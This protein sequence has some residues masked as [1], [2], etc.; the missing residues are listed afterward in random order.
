MTA[1]DDRKVFMCS[2]AAGARP[3]VFVSVGERFLLYHKRQNI[4][5]RNSK[6]VEFFEELDDT[7]AATSDN[8]S[9]R[10]TKKRQS[11]KQEMEARLFTRAQ[12]ISGASFNFTYKAAR[13]EEAWL[14]DSLAPLV[15]HKWISDVLRKAKA[16]KEAS[17]YLCAPGPAARQSELVAAKVYRPRMLRNLKNDQ[18]YR[19]GRTDLDSEGKRVYKDADLHAIQKRSAH[20]EELRHQSW[21]A[22][23]FLAMETLFAAGA[24]V[25]RPYERSGNTIAMEFIGDALG[26]APTLNEVRLDRAEALGLFER[27]MRNVEILLANG[28]IHG[29]LSAYNILYWE[30][31]IK[32]IDFPQVV[33]P[34][35]N[36]SAFRIFSRDVTRLCE[37]F[38]SQ[39]VDTNPHQIAGE[40]WMRH[41]FHL[42]EEI[43]PR[44]LD[45]D[46]PRDRE[47]WAGQSR[48]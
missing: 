24:D 3:A 38:A 9:A 22:Y 6:L 33:A 31:E 30:G 34:K 42:R 17:V 12:E 45:P 40:M 15:D 46:D 25:P 8:A 19:D 27:A 10:T 43:H 18:Q 21:I 28:F 48:R 26:P 39:G 47:L 35:G 32:L 5:M 37:Y 16:G 4:N 1:R 23:E 20:G 14:Y 36:H 41:G 7:E 11:K 2:F 13:F 44:H 29:D